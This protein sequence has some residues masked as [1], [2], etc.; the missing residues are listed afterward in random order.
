M[1]STGAAPCGGLPVG[2]AP[3]RLGSC[4]P[5][6]GSPPPPLGMVYAPH[7]FES[8]PPGSRASRNGPSARR[9]RCPTGRS[10][11]SD[12]LPRYAGDS[13]TDRLARR[14][15]GESDRRISPH[16][17]H[18]AMSYINIVVFVRSRRELETWLVCHGQ[19]IR[20]LLAQ[21]SVPTGGSRS[22]RKFARPAAASIAPDALKRNGARRRRF[23]VV[24]NGEDYPPCCC[25]NW[26]TPLRH[27]ASADCRAW[28]STFGA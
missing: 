23:P 24:R 5:D 2:A 9:G 3:I 14:H 12:V 4:R 22:I 16:S 25:Q 10:C 15:I 20:V 19:R 11:P 18:C 27:G 26:S 7:W 8:C 21:H 13:R 6:L 17:K 1:P 28:R